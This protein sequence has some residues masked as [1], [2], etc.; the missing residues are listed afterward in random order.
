MDGAA[1]VAYPNL[2]VRQ[3]LPCCRGRVKDGNAKNFDYSVRALL[4]V[5]NSTGVIAVQ[6]GIMP[7]C[8]Y[9]CT[10]DSSLSARHHATVAAGA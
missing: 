10:S 4:P 6:G 5:P 7:M 1:T 2:A 3:R 8:I 9:L